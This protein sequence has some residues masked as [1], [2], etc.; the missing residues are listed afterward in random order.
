ILCIASLALMLVKTREASLSWSNSLRFWNL[1]HET[2]PNNPEIAYFAGLMRQERGDY[3]SALKLYRESLKNDPNFVRA[4]FAT[5]SIF[6]DIGEYDSALKCY[7]EALRRDSPYKAEILA[8]LAQTHIKKREID[9]AIECFEKSLAIKDVP[10][11]R[12]WLAR[13]LLFKSERAKARKEAIKALKSG[14]ALT[15]DLKTA[16]PELQNSLP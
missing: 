2:K 9:S 1:E 7:N 10:E 4:Y 16:F 5:G 13:L 3:A 15:E 11:N 14:A 12:V 6:F 8:N